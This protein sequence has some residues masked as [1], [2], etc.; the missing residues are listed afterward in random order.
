MPEETVLTRDSVT[1]FAFCPVGGRLVAVLDAPVRTVYLYKLLRAR[2]SRE[3]RGGEGEREGKEA[4]D[5]V[6]IGDAYTV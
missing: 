6:L 2:R 1:F 4:H 5:I 3:G